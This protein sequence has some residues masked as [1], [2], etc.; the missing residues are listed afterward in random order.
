M[1][2]WVSNGGMCLVTVTVLCSGG[3]MVCDHVTISSYTREEEGMLYVL[4]G[5]RDQHQ[6]S[7]NILKQWGET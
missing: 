4:W 5:G 1:Q 6:L 7:Y 3:E 2:L